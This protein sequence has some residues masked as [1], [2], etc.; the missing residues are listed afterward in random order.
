MSSPGVQMATINPQSTPLKILHVVLSME[1]GGAEKLVYDMVRH[2]AF[3]D[4]RPVV[5]CLDAVGELG[6]RLLQEG[7]TVHSK[8]R[9]SGIDLSVIPWLRET[10]ARERITVV[11]AHQYTPLFYSTPAAIL[12]GGI[13]VV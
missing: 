12:A 2:P 7:Y 5:C 13:K 11:H 6:D 4:S 10:I 9:R 1:V 8:M 3:A